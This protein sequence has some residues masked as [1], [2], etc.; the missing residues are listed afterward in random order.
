MARALLRDA[1]T[2]LIAV[3]RALTL[4]D[5]LPNLPW[6]QQQIDAPGFYTGYGVKTP[7]VPEAI[8]QDEW[9]LADEQIGGM[10]QVLENA[11]EAIEGGASALGPAVKQQSA[12]YLRIPNMFEKSSVHMRKGRSGRNSLASFRSS[13]CASAAAGLINSAHEQSKHRKSSCGGE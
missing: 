13:G 1:N 7:A 12:A 3:E 8:E 11:G 5:G 2:R 6:F 4:S 10:G 9:K